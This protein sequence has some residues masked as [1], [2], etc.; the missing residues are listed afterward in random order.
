[1]ALEHVWL[2][3]ERKQGFDC[4][5]CSGFIPAGANVTGDCFY[6]TDGAVFIL[7]GPSA[8]RGR[9]CWQCERDWCEELDAYYGFEPFTGDLCSKC[10]K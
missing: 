9:V 5:R 10:R 2:W 8:P 1:M 7:E 6:P 4:A 3:S